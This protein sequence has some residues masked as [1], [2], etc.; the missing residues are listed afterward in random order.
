M[1]TEQRLNFFNKN[2]YS[3]QNLLLKYFDRFH[4][5]KDYQKRLLKIPYLDYFIRNFVFG[6]IDSN[7]TS[8]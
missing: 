6:V 5:I 1:S 4:F 7:Q 3:D 8:N 2:Y